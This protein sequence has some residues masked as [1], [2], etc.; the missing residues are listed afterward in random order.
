M[1]QCRSTTPAAIPYSFDLALDNIFIDDLNYDLYDFCSFGANPL[2]LAEDPLLAPAPAPLHNPIPSPYFPT[3]DHAY[4]ESSF[5]SFGAPVTYSFPAQT[6]SSLNPLPYI[7]THQ[8]SLT[9][10]HSI[11]PSSPSHH[12]PAEYQ[13]YEETPNLCSAAL[14]APAPATTMNHEY[15]SSHAPIDSN[16]NDNNSHPTSAVAISILVQP[17]LRISYMAPES[18]LLLGYHADELVGLS[19]LAL[20][21]PTDQYA[22]GSQFVRLLD[23]LWEMN[24]IVRL[25]C[26][27]GSLLAVEFRGVF[28]HDGSV[29]CLT[30]RVARVG[31]NDTARSKDAQQSF[32]ASPTAATAPASRLYSDPSPLQS[33][34]TAHLLDPAYNLSSPTSD[35]MLVTTNTSQ[36]YLPAPLAAYNERSSDKK[37]RTKMPQLYVCADCHTTESP[38]WRKGPN[39]PKTLCNACGLRWAKKEKKAAAAER[40]RHHLAT[41]GGARGSAA[42]CSGDGAKRIPIKSAPCSRPGIGVL[43]GTGVRSLA[44]ELSNES[45]KPG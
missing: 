7:Y 32:P 5:P 25:C 12:M 40:E 15:P 6:H 38:E 23:R 44:P 28:S 35:A 13:Y 41:K 14:A 17:S 43:V 20:V 21:C 1:S 45:W 19:L 22:F 2:P 11:S 16:N 33:A 4:T 27:D 30:G 24:A 26:S 39:G 34:R 36:M 18:A 9:Q 29:I 8:F 10:G 42:R 37:R 3:L 31:S